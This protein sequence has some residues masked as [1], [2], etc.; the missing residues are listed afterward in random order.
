MKPIGHPRPIDWQAEE[1]ARI[2]HRLL[3]APEHGRG[4]RIDPRT[5]FTY[6]CSDWLRDEPRRREPPANV[7]PFPRLLEASDR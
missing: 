1:G 5:G 3:P 6:Y 2:L 4:F 7:V